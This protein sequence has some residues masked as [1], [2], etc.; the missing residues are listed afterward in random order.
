MKSLFLQQLQFG[1]ETRPPDSPAWGNSVRPHTR[2]KTIS[3]GDGGGSVSRGPSLPSPQ[4]RT[5]VPWWSFW[6]W[7]GGLTLLDY[8]NLKGYSQRLASLGGL[9]LTSQWRGG[10]KGLCLWVTP[11]VSELPVCSGKGAWMLPLKVLLPANPSTLDISAG[12]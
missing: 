1:K 6:W 8:L 12:P 11:S 7:A 9:I 5:F 4:P 2:P 10:H 3:T